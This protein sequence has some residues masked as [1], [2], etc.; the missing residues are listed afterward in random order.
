MVFEEGSPSLLCSLGWWSNRVLANKTPA[1]V[2]EFMISP[3]FLRLLSKFF[4][5]LRWVRIPLMLLAGF[6]LHEEKET[7]LLLTENM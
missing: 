5:N 1:E 7:L 4:F 3:F 6:L 2:W